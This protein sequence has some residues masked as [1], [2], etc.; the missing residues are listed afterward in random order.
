LDSDKYRTD[1]DLEGS[2]NY[3]FNLVNNKPYPKFRDRV[4]RVL[5]DA[6]VEF[7]RGSGGG[8]QLRQPYLK[9]IVPDKEWKIL[10]LHKI[11]NNV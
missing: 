9:T 7:R 1:F 6:G 4:E 10:A 8:N 11:L 5:R 2:C 3:A